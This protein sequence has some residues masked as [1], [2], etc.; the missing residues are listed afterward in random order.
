[1]TK[2]LLDV[3]SALERK[4]LWLAAWMIHEANHVRDNVDGLKVGGHQASSAS[5]STIM[6]ALYFHVLRPQD[7][8]AVKPHASPIFHAIQYL[9]GRQSR[10]KL[11][12]FRGY[13][14][15]QSYPSRTK[16]T[17][18]VDFSTGSVGLGVA[19]TLFASLVQDYVHDHGFAGDRSPG[20]MIAL[21]GDAEM[22]EGNIFEALLEGWKQGVRNCWWIIDY[23]RQSLDAVVRE[24]LWEQYE[25]L[26]RAFGWDVVILKYG[27]LLE[28][29]FKKPGGDTLRAWIDH[30]PNQL[31]SALTFQ[32]GAAW[33]RRLTDDLGDQGP[34]SALLDALSDDDLARLMTNL[35]GH[36]LPTLLDAFGKIDH[37]RPTCIIA[38]T[39]KGHGLPL[40]G[41]KDNHAGLM[42][43]AQMEILRNAMKV[44]P[45]HE[46]D[47]F[48]G[49]SLPEHELRSFLEKVPFA[50]GGPRRLQAA[51]VD[52]PAALT[53]EIAPTMS[54]QQGFGV[55]LNEVGKQKS[56]FSDRIVTTSPDVTMSTNLGAFVNRRGL[57]ARQ[58][59]VDTF[60]SE[61]IPSTLTWEFS[62]KGQHMEL[63]IAE[64]NLFILLSALGLSH[65]LFG[66]RLF[67]IGTLYDPF[68][69]RGLD[70]LNYAC[71]QDARFILVG[72]PSGI[73]LAPEGG[74]HQSIGT[75]LIGMAQDGLAAFEPSFVDELAVILGFAFDYIQR[76]GEGEACERTWLR[77]ETGGSVYLRLSTRPVEQPQRVMTPELR[78][79]IIDGAYWMR[80][81]GP[82]CQVVVAY[83]GAIAPEAIQAVGLMA[84]DRR[85]IGLLAVTSADRLNAGWTA[86]SR[87]RERGLPHARSHIERLM[88]ELPPHCGLVTVL[89][90]HPATLAWLGAVAGHRTRPL[91]VE[92]FGQTGAL[93][94]LHRHYGIDANAIVAA[95]Q[96][97]APGRPIR[98]LKAL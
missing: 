71:Y 50:Q 41:H 3:L 25:K 72:T 46:W 62:P 36:D 33:R 18:D 35:A 73:T 29:A 23:N 90:G 76:D 10:E 56:D 13:K 48:E 66:A 80:K 81:P 7:R 15:A 70:A 88:A 74:A 38:Y 92:H 19:Q 30:C 97:I 78:Q 51:R 60:K 32:G 83:T 53:V 63:G 40:A 21:V 45:G 65:S 17:D 6:T 75:P 82:N 22:D 89:D 43:T 79:G 84:E 8:V 87:A 52:V 28:E 14:G 5:L 1:M 49:L 12:A 94:D 91:G 11:A 67:P 39:V 26:F 93:P 96:A 77:D 95:A 57:F 24:G 42:T 31:Y 27:V 47:F 55:L 54:T 9:L 44:R 16:D 2:D 98:Y 61:R 37:D 4:V 20:R 69:C 64:M 86:A 85:D 58:P 68:V 59:M 34:L